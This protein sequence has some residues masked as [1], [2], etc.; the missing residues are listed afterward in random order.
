VVP[1]AADLLRSPYLVPA[2]P[3]YAR[4]EL[5]SAAMMLPVQQVAGT[6]S[7]AATAAAQQGLCPGV[8]LAAGLDQVSLVCGWSAKE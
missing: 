1:Q 8:V 7:A 2:V 4:G 6:P 3:G 5:A